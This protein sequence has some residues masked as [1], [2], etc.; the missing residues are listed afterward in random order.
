MRRGVTAAPEEVPMMIHVHPFTLEAL[1]KA[2]TR[3]NLPET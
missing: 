2:E 1:A 3:G